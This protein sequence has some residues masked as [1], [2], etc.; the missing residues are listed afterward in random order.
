VSEGAIDTEALQAWIG[1]R[2]TA[3][4]EVTTRLAQGLHATLDGAGEAPGPGASA[5]LAI[6]WCLS[7]TIVRAGELGPDGH[8]QRG[9][10][11]P[12]VP[13]PR[14]MWAGGRL[15]FHDRLRVGDSVE[16][17]STIADVTVKHG[18]SGVLCFVAVDH[19]YIGPRGLAIAER[20]DIVYRDIEAAPVKPPTP[21]VP[22]KP[23]TPAVPA[24]PPTPA[25]PAK[26]STPAVPASAAW[27]RPMQADTVM[28]FRYSALTFNGHRIHYDR[29]Y[30]QAVEHYPG[31]VVHG[32][33]QATWLIDYAATLGDGAP[34]WFSFR[35]LAPLFDFEPFELCAARSPTG[36]TLWIVTSDG[37]RTM[38]ADAS[39]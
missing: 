21:A 18:R 16:R 30:A 37:K 2:E 17:R 26:P 36:L 4:D 1:R 28:L 39:W 20:Q 24:K 7:P 14:R 3:R 23:P 33:L 13:L 27:R 32:P 22:V 5:A 11:L 35:S 29:T 38:Q 31:L 10:F 34:K 12:P 9:G 15:A 6:H 8:P 25:V 19:D